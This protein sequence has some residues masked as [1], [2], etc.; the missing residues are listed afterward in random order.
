MLFVLALVAAVGYMMLTKR[1]IEANITDQVN[2]YLAQQETATHPGVQDA[3]D[4]EIKELQRR[5]GSRCGTEDFNEALSSKEKRDLQ[6]I[7]SELQQ[8]AKNFDAKGLGSL[9]PEG[10]YLEMSVGNYY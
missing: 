7:E 3:T 9:E 10:I 5:V 6:T 2:E 8:E 1:T 4:A